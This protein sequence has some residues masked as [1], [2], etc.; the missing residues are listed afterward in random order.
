MMPPNMPPAAPWVK[1]HRGARCGAGGPDTPSVEC[2]SGLFCATECFVSTC[3][4]VQEGIGICQPC[5]LCTA[6]VIF[7]RRS[8]CA[9]ECGQT[10]IEA[11]AHLQKVAV[12]LLGKGGQ[13]CLLYTGG[14]PQLGRPVDSGDLQAR[15]H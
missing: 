9:A 4:A 10:G 5:S 3:E 15:H 11:A 2:D 13:M 7:K 12:D 1:L 6:D 8:S 14:V